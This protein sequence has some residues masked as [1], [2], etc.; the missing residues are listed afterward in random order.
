[1][2]KISVVKQT[3]SGRNVLFK[4]NV[5]GNIMSLNQFVKKIENHQYDNYH[6]RTINNIKTPCSNPDK[7]INNNLG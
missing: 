6:I 2:K 4:D 7:S 3:A 5:K 1:M